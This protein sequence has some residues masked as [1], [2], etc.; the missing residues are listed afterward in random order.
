[1]VWEM[2]TP[3]ASR[4]QISIRTPGEP[5]R[6]VNLELDLYVLGRDESNSLCFPG[7][8]G[9][10]RKHLAFER[11]GSGWLVRDLGSTNG[12]FVSGTRISE[13]RILR[14]NDQVTAG[15]L[16]IVFSDAPPAAPGRSAETVIFLE[17]GAAPAAPAEE[18][19]LKGVLGS[20]REI[21]GSAHMRALIDAGR[22]LCGH[23]S[24]DE[25]FGVIMNLSVTA[26]GAARGVLITLE[27][28]EFRVRASKGAGFQISSHV[29]DLVVKGK[30][31]LL[32]RDA[33]SDQALAARTSIVQGQIR[34]ILAV[35]LQTDD[36]VIGLIY[37]DS[38]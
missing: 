20:D 17:K 22:E 15:D 12:T 35:P 31:S 13:P 6:T 34:G 28:G 38:P 18:A 27:E 1:M 10:S 32:V 19:T 24:L 36:Q 14:S 7:V 33:L 4:A 2:P 9:L 30:R 37:L 8:P 26:V 21:Q 16:S 23:S 3:K 11:A 5:A 29:R 25:L